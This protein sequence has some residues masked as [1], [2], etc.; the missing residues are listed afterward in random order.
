MTEINKKCD[1]FDGCNHKDCEKDFCLRK[2]KLNKLMDAAQLSQSQKKHVVLRVDADGT[3]L[4][5]LQKISAMLSNI[6]TFVADGTNLYLHSAI[7]GNG[8]TT[9]AV[10][11]I[12]TY[13][14]KIWPTSDLRCRALFVNVPR[15][16][17]A[18]KDNINGPNAYFQYIVDNAEQADLV[19]WDD[20]ATKIATQYET[21]RL[22][23]IIDTRL[24]AGKANIFTSNL[25]REGMT[26]A[27]DPRLVSRIC[28][29]A[30]EIELKGADKRFLVKGDN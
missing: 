9:I 29:T 10:R 22:L 5:E 3:D 18:M 16:V 27:L 1:F 26:K 13:L 15:F 24:C 17:L 11:F 12:Q 23:P 19:I 14:K 20:I 4:A 2:Y 25:D 7:C 30:L 21:D 6:E 8:K 28:S